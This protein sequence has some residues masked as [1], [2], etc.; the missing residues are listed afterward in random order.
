MVRDQ[1]SHRASSLPWWHDI[2]WLLIYTRPSPIGSVLRPLYC[3]ISFH[4][5]QNVSASG[6]NRRSSSAA[7]PVRRRV[8]RFQKPP[9]S[10]PPADCSG[11]GVARLAALT[12]PAPDG[13]IAARG[14]L[15]SEINLRLRDLLQSFS[16]P[17][18]VS[19]DA[20]RM[21]PPARSSLLVYYHRRQPST[22]CR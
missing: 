10:R 13:L 20:S 11:C 12:V 18:Y 19:L 5:L 9:E 22:P 6:F 8:S 7:V 15:F 14:H 3:P 4:H 16:T 17:L 1:D 2:F 21:M